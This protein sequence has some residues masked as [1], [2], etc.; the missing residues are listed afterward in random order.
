MATQYTIEL[1]G[2][3]TTGIYTYDNQN[4]FPIDGQL[5]GNETNPHN[6]HFTYEIHTRFAYNPGD[7][8]RFTGDDDLWVFINGRLGIDL[9]GVHAPESAEINL[10]AQATTLGIEPGKSYDLDFFFAER[11]T[12][13]STFRIDTTLIFRP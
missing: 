11:H 7:V 4:F 2:D 9:G 1:V 5:F 3:V 10:D 8:F 6:Y 12:T 13:Q